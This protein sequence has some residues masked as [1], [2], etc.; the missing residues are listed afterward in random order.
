M[1]KVYYS[2]LQSSSNIKTIEWFKK[3]N[4]NFKEIRNKNISKSDLIH[5][6]SISDSGFSTIL[7]NNLTS[8]SILKKKIEQ[9]QY[10]NFNDCIRFILNTPEVLKSPIVFEDDKL[11]VGFNTD[12]I[13]KFIPPVYRKKNNG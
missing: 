2:G 12:E 5:I 10:M 1:I 7:K 6:L 4:I 11:L 13:R 8:R 9:L 3:R